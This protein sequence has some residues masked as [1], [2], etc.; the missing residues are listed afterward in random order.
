MIGN[1][2]NSK[3]NYFVVISSV[4]VLRFVCYSYSKKYRIV[5]ICHEYYMPC[6]V[7]Y[8]QVLYEASS[9]VLYHIYVGSTVMIYHNDNKNQQYG[10]SNRV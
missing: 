8:I 4:L 6:Q 1:P 3:Y 7:M 10:Q 5:R 9:L 2:C